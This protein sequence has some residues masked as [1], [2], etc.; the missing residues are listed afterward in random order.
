MQ[1][2]KTRLKSDVYWRSLK[3]FTGP[4]LCIGTTALRGMNSEC[5]KFQMSFRYQN[6]SD[7]F[8]CMAQWRSGMLTLLVLWERNSRQNA[9]SRLRVPHWQ[10]REHRKT[11][12]RLSLNDSQQPVRMVAV[13]VAEVES[14]YWSCAWRHRATVKVDTITGND[15][16]LD[17]WT[18]VLWWETNW[19]TWQLTNFM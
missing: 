8:H 14:R 11:K 5:I 6:L 18:D 9:W 16:Q 17:S 13:V 15:L 3:R 7:Q 1:K 19:G 2:Q 12:Q 10:R 4:A